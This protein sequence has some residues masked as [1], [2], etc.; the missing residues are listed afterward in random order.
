MDVCFVELEAFT[1]EVLRI[2]DEETL[3]QFEIELADNPESGDL[4]RQSGGLR[5]VRMKLAGRGKSAGGR[6]IYLWLPKPRRFIFF[7]FYTKS[8]QSTLPPDVLARLRDAVKV[9][10]A[11]YDQ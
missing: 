3:R 11:K 5:K 2:T 7:A 10:K 6:V 9:I 8:T 4:I 1:A